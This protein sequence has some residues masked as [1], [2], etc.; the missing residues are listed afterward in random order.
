[1]YKP[2]IAHCPIKRCL[3]L[4]VLLTWAALLSQAQAQAQPQ[5][6]TQPPQTLV[7]AVAIEKPS[8]T[9]SLDSILIGDDRRVAVINGEVVGEGD[10]LADTRIVRIGSDNVLV[11]R[12]GESARLELPS[13][14]EVRRRREFK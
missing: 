9:L 14:P 12:A 2:K 3:L 10:S 11:R 5:D 13:A 8:I 1:V 4:A 7:G 6:P